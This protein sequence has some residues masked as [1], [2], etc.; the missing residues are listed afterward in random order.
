MTIQEL[1]DQILLWAS[2]LATGPFKFRD[3]HSPAQKQTT[4]FLKGCYGERSS[5]PVTLCG[6]TGNTRRE[7]LVHLAKNLKG[8]EAITWLKQHDE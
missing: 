3:N 8:E 6:G 5:E 4:V 2:D 1:E 7:A